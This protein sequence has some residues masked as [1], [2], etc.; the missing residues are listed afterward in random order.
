[1]IGFKTCCRCEAI[2]RP[3]QFPK[4][5]RKP[6]GYAYACKECKSKERKNK[7]DIELAR[8]KKYYAVGTEARKRHIVRSQTRKKFGSA[9]EQKCVNCF[10]QAQEWH[11][12]EYK[13]DEVIPVCREC[14]NL[15]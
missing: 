7:Q 9:K 2:K 10:K 3:E 1:M 6:N 13:V 4:D 12:I 14:H 11:H 8:W 15:I 5:S